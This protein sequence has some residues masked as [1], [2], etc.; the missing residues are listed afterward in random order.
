MMTDNQLVSILE[1]LQSLATPTKEI[2]TISE[3]ATYTGLSTSYLYKLT[4]KKEIPFFKP[5]G[6]RVYF[7]RSELDQWLLRNRQG[8]AS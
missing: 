3:C 4:S 1:Q 7:K 6:K 8:G 5:M 2:M